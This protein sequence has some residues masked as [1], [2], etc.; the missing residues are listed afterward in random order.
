MKDEATSVVCVLCLMYSIFCQD[1]THCDIRTLGLIGML[2]QPKNMYN[3]NI[4]NSLFCKYGQN[5]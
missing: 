4:S 1:L 5:P 2:S 3:Y